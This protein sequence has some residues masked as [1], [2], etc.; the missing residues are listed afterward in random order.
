MRNHGAELKNNDWIFFAL[1]FYEPKI[2]HSFCPSCSTAI[3]NVSLASLTD[4]TPI[5][6]EPT[7]SIDAMYFSASF[8]GILP[9]AR[10]FLQ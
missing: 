3:G 8:G 1:D 5:A 7:K 10:T 4:A 6:T 2:S 9:A